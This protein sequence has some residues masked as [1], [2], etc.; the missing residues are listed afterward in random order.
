[1]PEKR[2]DMC[3]LLYTI[4]ALDRQTDRRTDI[5]VVQQYRVLQTIASM[6]TRDR[7]LQ[8][9]HYI[10]VEY[11]N[12]KFKVSLIYF[13]NHI[14]FVYQ[15]ISSLSSNHSLNNNSNIKWKSES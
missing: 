9:S 7:H 10:N 13:I 2:Y 14:N 6:L 4:P 1:L 12:H 11:Y 8:R 3:I 15:F 5:E